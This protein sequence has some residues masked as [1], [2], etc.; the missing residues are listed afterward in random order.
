MAK[1]G[2]S[3]FKRIIKAATYSWQGTKAAY[4]HEAAFRQ[5]CWLAFILIPAGFYIGDTM[6]EKSLLISSLLFILVVELLNSAIEAVVDRIGDQ[7]HE[8]AGRAK[9]MGSAAVM[10]SIIL[11]AVIWL[12]VLIPSP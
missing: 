12:A 2:V 3:G 4:T 8:L 10:I 5:E 7:H 9:D 11:A 1:A 6:L